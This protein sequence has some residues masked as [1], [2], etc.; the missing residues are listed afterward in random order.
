MKISF[1]IRFKNEGLNIQNLVESI[2][3]QLGGFENEMIFV[4]DCSDDESYQ[5][6]KKL[7]KNFP[8]RSSVKLINLRPKQFTYST[9]INIALPH[10][11]G[12]FLFIPTAHV[13]I[14]D[15]EAIMKMIENFQDKD[16]VA[17]S[18]RIIPFDLHD[19]FSALSLKLNGT[20]ERKERSLLTIKGEEERRNLVNYIFMCAFSCIRASVFENKAN[21][22]RELPRSEDLEWSYR[23][24]NKGH[25]IV[26]DPRITIRHKNTDSITQICRRW[27]Y[28]IVSIDLILRRGISPLLKVYYRTMFSIT[29]FMGRVMKSEKRLSKKCF[30]LFQLVTICFYLPLYI[31]FHAGEISRWE[32]KYKE[33]INE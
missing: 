29:K 10:V 2:L 4:N 15:R 33:S 6:V 22:F 32:N 20:E 8:P 31:L 30:Y 26:H 12:E 18:V 28:S 3:N 27:L 23:M 11:T 17:V 21:W 16:V 7:E 14:E 9:A 24:I 5:Y 13:V 19:T 25:K 1:I